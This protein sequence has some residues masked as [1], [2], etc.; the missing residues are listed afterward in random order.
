MSNLSP[1]PGREKYP[2]H[3]DQ[4]G[5]YWAEVPFAWLK[6]FASVQALLAPVALGGLLLWKSISKVGSD[7]TDLETRNHDSLQ[8]ID[9]AAHTHL[10]ATNA[11]DLT[12]GGASILHYHASDRSRANHTG[13]QTLATISDAGTAASHAS[14]DF[15]AAGLAASAQAFSVQRSNHTGTQTISTLS[16]LP[17][18]SSGAYLPTLTNVA[19]LDAST[20]Y[21]CQYLRI[22]S[23]VT[24]SGKIYLDPTAATVLTRLG[25]SLPIASTLANSNECAGVAFASGISG[26]GAAIIADTTNHR[27]ELQFISVDI[28]NQPMY[29]TFTYR[30]I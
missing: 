12:D 3:Q 9:T 2:V 7:I 14:T 13:T 16:D 19:N 22:G 30:I 6:W 27:A 21:S 10:S 28:T 1:P 4:G 29:F 8:N 5:S 11:T 18:L 17:T 15:D 23:S 24:V 25:I 26:Q 20:N